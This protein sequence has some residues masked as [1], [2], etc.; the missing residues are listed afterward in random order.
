MV[1]VS[2]ILVLYS[3]IQSQK[4]SKGA[5][6]NA[7]QCL[8]M[9]VTGD[10]FPLVDI[11]AFVLVFVCEVLFLFF[12]YVCVSYLQNRCPCVEELQAWFGRVDAP[13][14]QDGES[15]EGSGDGRHCPQGYGSD[16]ISCKKVKAKPF[17]RMKGHQV[18]SLSHKPSRL[19]LSI[20]P[21]PIPPPTKSMTSDLKSIM[22]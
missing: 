3:I 1:I 19:V 9:Q 12:Q 7:F 5:I 21:S 14:S 2:I 16:G 15:G 22:D 18:T 8:C 17:D 10:K 11:F 4:H 6:Y 20:Y 13:G